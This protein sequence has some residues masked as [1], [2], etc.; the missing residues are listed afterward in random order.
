MGAGVNNR[1]Y[2]LIKSSTKWLHMF[3]YAYI[4]LKTKLEKHKCDIFRI[5]CGKLQNQFQFDQWPVSWP[6]SLPVN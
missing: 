1:N 4:K 3:T 2:A 6:T 5:V